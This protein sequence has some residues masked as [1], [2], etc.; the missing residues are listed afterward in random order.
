M[1]SSHLS[2]SRGQESAGISASEK[3]LSGNN[4]ASGSGAPYK[5]FI[6][7]QRF[8]PQAYGHGVPVFPKEGI[9]IAMMFVNHLVNPDIGINTPD[10]L[11][12]APL[13][14]FRFIACEK[15]TA[16]SMADALIHH[17]RVKARNYKATKESQE[18]NSEDGPEDRPFILPVPCNAL[19]AAP[20][21]GNW[22]LQF[23]VKSQA[24]SVRKMFRYPTGRNGS[25]GR[26]DEFLLPSKVEAGDVRLFMEAH[27]VH[28]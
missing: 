3:Y 11:D 24:A 4:P 12:L 1:S 21:D 6:S 9:R 5:P 22:K 17:I 8:D 14:R 26:L 28:K 23:W 10:Q 13:W 20:L 16:S 7:M 18:D 2:T 25:S 19:F 15:I 27:I